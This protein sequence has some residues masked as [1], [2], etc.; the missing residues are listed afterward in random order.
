MNGTQLDECYG[1]LETGRV[2]Q[3]TSAW[4]REI[5]QMKEG[6]GNVS[7]SNSVVM[8]YEKKQMGV[9]R[10]RTEVWGVTSRGTNV[11]DSE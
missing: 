3:L 9:R 4:N 1:Y 10:R 5:E 11:G 6:H 7:I 8:Y 2:D